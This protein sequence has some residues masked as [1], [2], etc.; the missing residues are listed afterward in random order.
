MR[1]NVVDAPVGQDP[2]HSKIAMGRRN[3]R[4]GEMDILVVRLASIAASFR[5][6]LDTSGKKT[7][8]RDNEPFCMERAN[9]E[10]HCP[11]PPTHPSF[12]DHQTKTSSCQTN[13]DGRAEQAG[14]TRTPSNVTKNREVT[15]A[16][17]RGTAKSPE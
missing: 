2:L 4:H 14:G 9:I 13:G 3:D 15:F 16:T 6:A 10:S 17:V 1:Q 11:C 12:Q 7:L 5:L 8:D